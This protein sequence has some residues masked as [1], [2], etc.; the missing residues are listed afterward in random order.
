MVVRR[1]KAITKVARKH[2]RAAW[3]SFLS[4]ASWLD[5]TKPNKKKPV[6]WLVNV[7]MKTR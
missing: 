4:S 7:N 6:S 2:V 5:E 1:I 3:R